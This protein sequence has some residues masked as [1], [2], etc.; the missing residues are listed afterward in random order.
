MVILAATASVP[1]RS[2]SRPTPAC[3]TPLSLTV[4]DRH[5]IALPA[6]LS[7]T[8]LDRHHTQQLPDSTSNAL[9]K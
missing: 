3:P 8:V 5:H 6:P 2:T 7:L 1:S 4:L 9:Q